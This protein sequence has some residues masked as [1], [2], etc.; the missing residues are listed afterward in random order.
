MI[1]WIA[2]EDVTLRP[3]AW[4]DGRGCD[5]WILHTA[6]EDPLHTAASW[7]RH[8]KATGDAYAE[9]VDAWVDY[10]ARLGIESI[11][12]GTVVVHKRSGSGNWTRTAA[13]PP[14]VLKPATG[15]LLQLFAAQELLAEAPGDAILDRRLALVEHAYVDRTA[16]VESGGWVETSAALRLAAGIEFGVNLDRYGSALVCALDGKEPIRDRLG[17]LAAEL[18]VPEP[19]FAAFAAH[20]LHHLVEHGFA[21]PA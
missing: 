2:G 11:A 13:L 9:R 16:R 3:R 4:L 5:A 12:Y 10:Y 17:P 6:A 1:S 18:G 15:H 7:N 20:L 8:A 14:G 21:M 19:E